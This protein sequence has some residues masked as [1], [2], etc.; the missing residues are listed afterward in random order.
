MGTLCTLK[1]RRPGILFV[2]FDVT[3]T[4]R[5]YLDIQIGLASARRVH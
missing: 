1:A 5:F 3:L 4:S 2:R